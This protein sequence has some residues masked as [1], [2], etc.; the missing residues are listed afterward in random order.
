MR[1]ET[2][3]IP[4]NKIQQFARSNIE[5]PEKLVSTWPQKHIDRTQLT[6]ILTD[7]AEETRR[8][9]T[10]NKVFYNSGKVSRVTAVVTDKDTGEELKVIWWNVYKNHYN[11]IY[12]LKGKDV[13]L[14]G[15][16]KSNNW[17]NITELQVSNPSIFSED[18]TGNLHITAK[19]KSIKGM[20]EEYY[21]SVL[22]RAYSAMVPIHDTLPTDIIQQYGLISYQNAVQQSHWP[23]SQ[24]SLDAAQY[25]ILWDQ[26][27]YYAA[28]VELNQRNMS[29]GSPYQLRY[30]QLFKQTKD[31]LPFQL[32]ADQESTVTDILQTIQS[33]MRVNAL[34]QGD[35]G[36][37]KTIV[38][39]LL[40][41]AFAENGY[42]AALMAPTQILAQQHYAKL[43]ELAQEVGIKTAF[44]SGKKLRK[45]E[46]QALNDSIS[47]GEVKLIVGTQ[48]L[49]SQNLQFK[50]LALCVTDEEHKYGVNQRSALTNQAAAGV[51][52]ISMSATPIPRTLAQAVFGSTLQLYSII[53]KPPGRKPVLTGIAR[54]MPAVYTYLRH[55]VQQGHQAYVV[56]PMIEDNDK[57]EGV[58]SVESISKKYI[59]ALTP[60]GICIGVVTGRTKKE[61][62]AQIIDDFAN[63]R[64]HVLIAT[65]VIEVGVDVPNATAIIIHNAERFGLAQLHQ[66]RGRVGRSSLESICCLVSNQKDNER[67]QAMCNTNDGFKIA[68]EDLR[69]RGAGDLLGTAQS[70]IEK[71]LTLALTHP[72]EFQQAKEAV[73]GMLNTGNTCK[74]L[75]TAIA[76]TAAGVVGEMLIE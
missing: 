42:Q 49:L 13:L 14:C 48:A 4:K 68:E 35:V 21:Q 67:L 19:Y 6:P 56:C 63:N 69:L 32:T 71:Y 75:E 38:A 76:D 51:H 11:Q 47:S 34:I 54:D 18:I 61:E 52:V 58:E 65:T 46:Q 62:A 30:L 43:T 20:S 31:S 50:E 16:V 72:V 33:G 45:A 2:L 7:Q 28:R 55:T 23:D 27:F 24:A 22:Q 15:L 29:L 37:G 10:V 60:Q 12:G 41:I 39:F 8:V 36:S 44:V 57:M 17:N 70:G 40:M 9:V 1:W 5:T 25:R 73:Q 59:S 74:L 53:T 64:I 3:S 66:L 26:L